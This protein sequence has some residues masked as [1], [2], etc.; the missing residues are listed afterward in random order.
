ML[1][2]LNN[3]SLLISASAFLAVF[4]FCLGIIQFLRE[5][6]RK[7]EVVEKIK[8]GG[9]TIFIPDEEK[10]PNTDQTSL[11]NTLFFGL[12]GKIGNVA[13]APKL[14]DNSNV[15]LKFFRA[16]IRQ[17]NAANI[18]WGFKIFCR[19]CFWQFLLYCELRYLNS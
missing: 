7:R 11:L 9:E 18:F 4:L 1:S 6:N 17:D 5:R 3:L 8:S 10:P 15:R 14:S 19:F 12:F 2:I 16:G 13:K